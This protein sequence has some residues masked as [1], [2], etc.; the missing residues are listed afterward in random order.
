MLT[1]IY[2][3]RWSTEF[4]TCEIMLVFRVSGFE[5]LGTSEVLVTKASPVYRNCIAVI[6]Q[7]VR[8]AN[9]SLSAEIQAF[10]PDTRRIPEARVTRAHH[11]PVPFPQN[12]KISAKSFS[13]LPPANKSCN[14]S[15]LF[16]LV[17]IYDIQS[18]HLF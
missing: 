5:A 11:A 1:E 17:H 6:I 10:S 14:S 9:W 3:M 13:F 4:S 15:F 7:R 2:H 16:L 12:L 18:L 8:T